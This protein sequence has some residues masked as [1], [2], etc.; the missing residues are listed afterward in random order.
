MQPKRVILVRH[1]DDPP[2]DRA[3][4]YFHGAG[5]EPVVRRPFRGESV[6]EPVETLAGVVVHGGPYNA[7]DTELHPF[8][9]EE[10]ALIDRCIEKG[11]PLLGIC[12]GAQMIALHLGAEVGP[13]HDMVA[14]FGYYEIE[15]AEDAA[16]FMDAPILACQSHFHTFG[17]PRGATR[18]AGSA[19]FPNQAFRHGPSTYALQFHAEV[20]VE[21]FRRWQENHGAMYDRPGVQSR[22]EQ[23]ALMMK[24]D[25]EQAA[26]FH[27]FMRR[28]FG[29]AEKRSAAV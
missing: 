23:D 16:G 11:V 4:T 28:L 6:D 14:E 20:T 26:W 18:L 2:D 10:Y 8:L 9:K 7:F 17:I 21:G 13:K 29:T 12:Q 27:G 19:L 15:P 1:G 24:A 3:F 25:A 5:F 22:A